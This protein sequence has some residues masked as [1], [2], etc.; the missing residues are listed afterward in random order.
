[1]ETI[2][3]QEGNAVGKY[4]KELR[5]TCT[6]QRKSCVEVVKKKEEAILKITGV[7]KP[8]QPPPSVV[9]LEQERKESEEVK[10]KLK[11]FV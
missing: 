3:V 11:E 7:R 8:T 6:G 2:P 4:W 5:K 1:M 10:K 9:I